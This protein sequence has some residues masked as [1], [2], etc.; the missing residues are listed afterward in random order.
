MPRLALLVVF[1]RQVTAL[2]LAGPLD[3]LHAAETL[4]PGSYDVR[5]VAPRGETVVTDSG[6]G[7]VPSGPLPDPRSA[8]TIVVCSGPGADSAGDDMAEVVAWVAGAAGSVRRLASVCTGAF[9][10]ARAGL[11]DGRA[12]TTH[13]DDAADLAAAHPEVRVEPDRIFVRDGPVSTSAGVTAGIDLA[14]AFVEEDLGVDV[15]RAVARELVVFVKRPGGQTQ[16]STQLRW[17]LPERD[18][19]RDLQSWIAD[20]LRGDLGVEA[21][22]ERAGMSTRTFA[23]AFTREIGLTPAAYVEAVRLE[24]AR[25]ALEDSGATVEGVAQACGFGTVETFRRAFHRRLGVTPSEYRD[26]FRSVA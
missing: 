7:I 24:A 23:R 5:V 25:V 20:N 13:W 17:R 6:V 9:V 8:D 3:V 10:L 14:L 15:A 16:F 4:R 21:L 2:D 11:L 22:A 12:A 26:R 18:P 19:L 1:G